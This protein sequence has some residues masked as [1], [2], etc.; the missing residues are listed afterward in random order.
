M[1]QTFSRRTVVKGSALAGALAATAGFGSI[2]GC[3]SNDLVPSKKESGPSK[4]QNAGDASVAYPAVDESNH[5]IKWANCAVN[6][7][8]RC[9]LQFLKNMVTRLS[10][11][12]TLQVFM[13]LP[14]DLG[15]DF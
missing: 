10:G 1:S 4:P 7:G 5:K 2:V 12:A 3:Q 13:H 8:S 11:S 9:A 14:V 15:I 6:C